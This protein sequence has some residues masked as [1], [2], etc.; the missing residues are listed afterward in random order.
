MLNLNI[1]N[2]FILINYLFN[3]NNNYFFKFYIIFKF[4]I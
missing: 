1:D 2:Y 3:N 4:I